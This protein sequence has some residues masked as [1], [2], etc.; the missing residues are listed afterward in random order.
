MPQS[1]LD[2]GIV[3]RF[4]AATG[5]ERSA[6]FQEIFLAHRDQVFGLCVRLCGHAALAEDAA[7]ET[8]LEVYKGLPLFRGDASLGTWIY[9]VAL[10][11]ALRLRAR[12]PPVAV[13]ADVDAVPAAR[14]PEAALAARDDIR[15]VQSALDALPAEQRVVV[16]LFSVDG[17]SHGEIASILGVPEGTVWSRL[18][19]GRK[20]LVAVLK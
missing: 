9:R 1:V 19:K 14:D 12:T 17:L 15:A 13:P 7:Q 10:R 6:V 4:R 8:F 18:H 3:A 20:A 5:G 11:T 2:G 16:A